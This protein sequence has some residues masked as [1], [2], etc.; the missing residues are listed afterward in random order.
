[1]K[2]VLLGLCS[3]FLLSAQD[4]KKKGQDAKGG[5]PSVDQEKVDQAIDHGVEYLRTTLNRV[6]EP[7]PLG[8]IGAPPGDNSG[9]KW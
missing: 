3:L 7:Q 5:A 6:M 2:V 4:A 9:S 8:G 1:V